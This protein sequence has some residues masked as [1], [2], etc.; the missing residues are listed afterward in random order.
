[1]S[2][3]GRIGGGVLKDNLL[4]DGSNLNFKNTSGSTALIHLDV[5]NGRVGINTESPAATYAL[6]VPSAIR[7]TG[8]NADYLNIQ[9]FTID[10]NRI[11]QN[12]GD[13]NLDATNNIFLAGL[14]T[15]NLTI[16]FNSIR[17][18][19]S[20]ENIILDPSGTGSVEI[21]SD[22]NI[23]GNLHSTGN[24]TF[25]GDLTLGDSDD[26]SITF[27]SDVNSH[28][29]PDVNDVSELGST[30]KYWNQTHTNVLNSASLS[31]ASLTIDTNVIKINQTDGNLTLNHTDAS[32]KVRLDSVDVLNDTISSSATDIDVVTAGELI[33]NS[34]TAVLLPAGTSAQRPT[35]AGGLRYNTD[36]GLYEGRAPTGYVSFGGVYSD[37]AATNVTAHPTNDTILFRA[38]NI[39]SGSI[40]SQGI[41][42]TGLLVDSVSA[43][44]NTITT[45]SGNTNLNFTPNGTGSVVID[46]IKFEQ[47]NITNTTNG[48]LEFIPTGQG[49]FKSGGTGGM[50]IPYGTTANRIP[51][52]AIGDTRWNTDTSTLESWDGTQYVLSAGQGGTVSEEYMNE[53]SLQYTIILG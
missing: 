18:N 11:Y 35:N 44:A 6:D 28:L 5:V 46:S 26:D 7:T 37:D 47:G 30:T 23:T 27:Q 31:S 1:M 10:T 4:R 36:T 49:Y 21:Y 3:L 41:N 45:D 51:N 32:R 25:G 20:N 2:Q 43:N 24:I 52:P 12:S 34:T 22:W 29:L 17:S 13:I 38:N 14:Q 53:L 39:A 40:D 50:V 16:N 9:N 48:A 15:D 42:L 33:F 19:Q 8:V